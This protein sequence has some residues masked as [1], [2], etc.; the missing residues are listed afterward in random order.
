M[1]GASGGKTSDGQSGQ[2]VPVGPNPFKPRSDKTTQ[3]GIH[4]WRVWPER[5]FRFSTFDFRESHDVDRVHIDHHLARLDPQP[6]AV[7]G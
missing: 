1:W 6:L 7:V 3:A 2:S 5:E 4:R